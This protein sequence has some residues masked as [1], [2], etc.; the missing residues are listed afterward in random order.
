MTISHKIILL[1]SRP[2]FIVTDFLLVC[3]YVCLSWEI[4][5]GSGKQTCYLRV[6]P[7]RCSLYQRVNCG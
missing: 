4:S 1:I 5:Y 7:L 3:M 6:S 2:F